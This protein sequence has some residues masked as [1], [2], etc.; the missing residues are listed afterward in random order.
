MAEAAEDIIEETT[1]EVT[2][3]NPWP[4]DWRQRIVGE[5]EKELS[6][7]GKY[8]TPKDIW[9]KAR[10]LEQQL[11]SGEYKRMVPYPEKGTDDEKTKWLKDNGIPDSPK[12]YELGREI[13][14]DDREPIEGFLE[15]A[16]Q[17]RMPPETVNAMVDYFFDRY[18]KDQEAL[19]EG[20]KASIES[21]E[22]ELR[23]EWGNEYRTNMNKIEG[24]VSMASKDA[25]DILSARLPDGSM[26]RGNA[27]AR[28]FLLQAAMA[29]NPTTTVVVGGGD[30]LSAIEDRMEE[31]KGKMNTQEYKKPGSKLRAEYMKLVEMQQ[32]YKK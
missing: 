24:L 7:I 25:G 12:G 32:R 18:E 10:S 29:V 22:D 5:D 6:H 31:I 23:T 15:Y 19:A 11:S 27:G 16:H 2:P 14:D 1:D 9:T 26:V 3:E 20:D 28:K 8:A 13:D 17:N 4:E 21:T 30:E